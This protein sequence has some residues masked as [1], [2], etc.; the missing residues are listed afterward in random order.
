MSGWSVPHFGLYWERIREEYPHVQVEHPIAS[1]EEVS[2][3]L[4]VVAVA[5]PEVRCWFLEPTKNRLI[6]VQRDRFIHNWRRYAEDEAEYPRYEEVIRPTFVREWEGFLAFLRDARVTIPKVARCEVTYINQFERGR[7]WE[8]RND[9]ANVLRPLEWNTD[10]LPPPDSTSCRWT[11]GLPDDRGTLQVVLVPAIRNRDAKE[12]F[13]LTLTAKGQPASPE[14][15]DL[16]EWMD[17]GREWIVRGFADL[18][19]PEMHKLWKRTS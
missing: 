16:L 4:R 5:V 19:T 3:G 15:E 12:I 10:F 17:F 7:E 14:T 8:H 2:K 6:Q 11:Y 1:Q 13:Q 18:T 9:I